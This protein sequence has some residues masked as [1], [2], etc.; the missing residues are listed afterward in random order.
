MRLSRIRRMLRFLSYDPA[1]VA[2]W[3]GIGASSSWAET[4][5]LLKLWRSGKGIAAQIAV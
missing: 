5:S 4:H 3:I 1:Q 2:E